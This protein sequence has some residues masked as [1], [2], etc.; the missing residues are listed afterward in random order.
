MRHLV[1]LG[2]HVSQAPGIPPRDDVDPGRHRVPRVQFVQL[3]GALDQAALVH[4]HDA[5]PGADLEGLP[6][7]HLV[8]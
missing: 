7:L 5:F 2:H 1:Q 8:L 4:V 6:G 3:E